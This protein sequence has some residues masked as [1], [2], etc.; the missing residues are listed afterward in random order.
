MDVYPQ[1]LG[2]EAGRQ[3]ERH[4]LWSVTGSVEDAVDRP[5]P[6]RP[7]TPLGFYLGWGLF[8]SLLAVVGLHVAFAVT[9]PFCM[10]G[11]F[12]WYGGVRSNGDASRQASGVPDSPEARLTLKEV[13]AM[14]AECPDPLLRRYWDLVRTAL[15]LPQS[16][17][18]GADG[19]RSVREALRALGG[20]I[21]NLPVRALDGL[22]GDTGDLRGAATRMEADAQGEA[23]VVVAASL[24]RR[25]EALR[26]QA[27][28]LA[29]VAVI[30]RRNA[31]LR[32][33]LADQMGA[34]RT[35]LSA[36]ALGQDAGGLELAGLAAHIRQVAR[37]ADAVTAAR[38]EV[39]T[40]LT[41]PEPGTAAR[42][43]VSP[44]R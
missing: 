12:V 30:L 35:S 23:D 40:L 25:A 20:A 24:G 41:R 27:E 32:D 10:I 33:E 5:A 38:V 17:G 31:A 4:R 44:P 8:A 16:D 22:P 15:T 11:A 1:D 28:T 43:R 7:V 37:E 6:R 19:E 39:D 3:I 21:E 9:F 14:Q 36:S 29:R 26:R 2:R 13:A 34:L 42:V 18:L